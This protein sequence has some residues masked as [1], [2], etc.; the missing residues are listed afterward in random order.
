MFLL[1]ENTKNWDLSE[2]EESRVFVRFE[3]IWISTKSVIQ[4]FS[5]CQ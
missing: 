5:N 1:R 4:L 2:Q 3:V